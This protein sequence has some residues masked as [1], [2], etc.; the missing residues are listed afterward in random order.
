MEGKFERRL[1]FSVA[2]AGFSS[3][4]TQIILLR[5]FLIIM[6]GNELVI[7]IILA[8]W[9][10]LTGAGSWL[11]RYA[12]GIRRQRGV[13]IL[14]QTL[15]AILPMITVFLLLYMRN[16]VF[17]VGVMISAVQVFYTSLILLMPFCLVSGFLFTLFCV[18]AAERFGR[19]LTGHVYGMESIGSA[20]GGVL[21]NFIFVFY[22]KAFNSL[23]FILL[24]N[25][26]TAFILSLTGR[27]LWSFILMPLG[28]ACL[29]LYFLINPG[30]IARKML[31]KG[32]DIRFEKDTPYGNLMVTRTG[33]QV[34][35]YENGVTLFSTNNTIQNEECVHY[36][37]IQH[38]H[39][40]KVLL[41]S[42][43]MAGALEEILKYNLDS[44][45]YVELNPWVVRIGERFISPADDPRITVIN[46]D[47]AL[48]IRHTTRTYDIVMINLPEPTTA[49]LNRFYS[50]DFFSVLKKKL[51]PGAV[52]STGLM[53]V[54]NYM[55]PEQRRT[56]SVLFNTMNRIFKH[57]LIIPGGKDY[58]L[59]S[60]DPLHID[61]AARIE[62]RGLMNLY[63][64]KYYIDDDLLK[65][66]SDQILASL[67]RSAGVNTD[68]KPLAYFQQMLLWLSYFKIDYRVPLV[69]MILLM[70]LVF[71]FFRPVY[72]GMFTGGFAASSVEF[73]ILIAF[74]VIYG[75]V[76]LMTGIIIMVFMAGLA[77]GVFLA[78]KYLNLATPALFIRVLAAIAVYSLVL[79]FILLLMKNHEIPVI[80]MHAFFFL[81]T[82]VIAALTGVLFSLGS[83][84]QR[85]GTGTVSGQVYGADLLGSALGILTVSVFLLP[86]F[87][88]TMVCIITGLLN[89]LSMFLVVIRK[90]DL[91]RFT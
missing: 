65:N 67:D 47:A 43:G 71:V 40:R 20:V 51:N 54:A 77:A 80:L 27:R 9:M 18:H 25:I 91:L 11:G 74:Q 81:L 64:N 15:M 41:V 55:S 29:V 24:L 66:R 17:P 45:D 76:F 34:N 2:V 85:G 35:V 8:N 61:I 5:E 75:Y 19:N 46:R 84:L 50:V 1:F 78:R 60:D 44:I 89:L 53:S 23:L 36:A 3:F 31:Y 26:V 62:Q 10:L 7:G 58:F 21:F 22:L 37:M 59:A 6:Y 32:Q 4:I 87:G 69:I 38:P 13:I 28:L 30:D 63:V 52:V 16:L 79:P 72:L 39:P 49:Q 70:A 14:L 86:L 42:G 57:V 88:L 12:A 73:L 56:H 83:R 68:F 82:L 48:F 33:D 90:R